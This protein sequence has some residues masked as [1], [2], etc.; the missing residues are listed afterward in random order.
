MSRTIIRVGAEPMIQQTFGDFLDGQ[1]AR[2]HRVAVSIDD[3]GPPTLVIDPP[4]GAPIHWPLDQVRQVPDQADGSRMILRLSGP[5]PARLLV[6]DAET[7]TI[8]RAR[9][10]RLRHTPPVRN[11]RRLLVWSFGA[12]ASVALIIFLL[13]PLMADQLAE[14]LPPDGEKALGD[15]TFE[16]IRAALGTTDLLPLE[17]CETPDGN[18]A[19][20]RMQAVLVRQVDL[21]YPLEIHV[22]DHEMINAFALPGGQVVLFRGLIDAAQ[23]SDEVAAVLAHEIGHVVNRDPAREALRSAGSVGVLG[24]IF[25]DFAGGTAVLFLLNRLIDA[26]YSQEAEANADRFAHGA[27][28]AAGIPPGA[29][30]TMFERLREEHGD[31]DGLVAHFQAHPTLGDRIE[32]AT[33]ANSLLTGAATPSLDQAGWRALR[34]ICQTDDGT[35]EKEKNQRG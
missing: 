34:G 30:A 15:A 18:A 20:D 22:L 21:P 29:L 16:Q 7:Q 5:D 3:N 12:L 33:A 25:G 14:F 19:L 31:S 23:S 26:T 28:A 8:L 35:V 17:I 4:E 9:C 10:P 11:R 6:E 1:S 13:V 27:L 2:V 24:L 32:A